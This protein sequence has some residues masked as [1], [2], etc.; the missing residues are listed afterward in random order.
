MGTAI[1]A[2]PTGLAAQDIS[3]LDIVVDPGNKFLFIANQGNATDI[4]SGSILVFAISGTGLTQVGAPVPVALPTATM[5]PGPSALAVTADSKFLY[6]ANTF[7]GSVDG[8]SVDSSGNLTSQNLPNALPGSVTISP[9]GL[10]ISPDGS[11]LYVATF[12]SNQISA[13]SICDTN[14]STCSDV[15]NPDGHLTKITT[16]FPETTGLGPTRMVITNPTQ[17]FLYSIGQQ[18]NEIFP[19]KVSTGSGA[20]TPLAGLNTGLTPTGL[21]GRVGT[22]VNSTTGGTTNYLY[23]ANFGGASI[24]SFSYDST[25]GVLNSVATT[26]TASGQPVAIAVK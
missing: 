6:V 5:N 17:P 4:S 14:L 13:F 8:Y 16:N 19:F 22:S 15:N 7:D 21:A 18:S 20:L 10:V 9:S 23:V 11:L 1:I 25:T 24:S 12:G 3:P 2:T 26:A